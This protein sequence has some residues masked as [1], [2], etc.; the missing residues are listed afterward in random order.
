[1]GRR[2]YC[3]Y[4]DKNFLDVLEARRKH[5]QSAHHIK[6]RNLHYEYSRGRILLYTPN[7]FFHSH[8]RRCG[9]NPKGRIA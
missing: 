8:N 9:N 7:K 6:L 3:D 4:C 2:Y 5:L 1:M